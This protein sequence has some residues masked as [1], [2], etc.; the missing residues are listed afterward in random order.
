MLRNT[1][2]QEKDKVHFGTI[3]QRSHNPAVSLRTLIKLCTIC[4]C[5]QQLCELHI[6]LI[7]PT[8]SRNYYSKRPSR[9]KIKLMN[10]KTKDCNPSYTLEHLKYA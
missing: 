2:P 3:N 1:F 9:K 6:V 10:L 7:L 5:K 4:K 8:Y